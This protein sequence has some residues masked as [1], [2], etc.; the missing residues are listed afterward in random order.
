MTYYKFLKENGSSPQGYGE[1]HLP[2]SKRP[3]KWMPKIEGE[4]AAC[5]NGYHVLRDTDLIHWL[6]P[7]LWEVE[8]KGELVESG[9]KCITRQA[10]LI[11]KVDTWNERSQ[12]L[13]ACWCA[14]RVLHLYEKQ[15][16]DDSRVRQCIETARL[17]AN[18][19]ATLEDLRAAS[20]ASRAASRAASEAASRA[21]RAAQSAH[22][23]E[24]LEL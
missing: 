21:S 12:R 6:G 10:R 3:G 11:R 20:W 19:K 16:P 18:G 23:L 17:Y 15:Y 8:I 4:L 24:I 5:E 9:D 14:E 7:V 22:L 1:W 2:K 13:F